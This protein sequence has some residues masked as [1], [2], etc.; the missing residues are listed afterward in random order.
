M[1]NEEARHEVESETSKRKRG[2]PSKNAEKEREWTDRETFKSIN[3]WAYH[4]C[5]YNT[6]SSAYLNK[7]KQIH[8]LDKIVQAFQDTEK[9]LTRSQKLLSRGKQQSR[10]VQNK[11]W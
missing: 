11:W 8:A 7:N 4:E 9:P 3:L 5:L 10:K 2:R 6:N 1:G